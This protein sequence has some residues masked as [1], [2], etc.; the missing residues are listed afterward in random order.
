MSKHFTHNHPG[1]MAPHQPPAAKNPWTNL[2]TH[3]PST[4]PPMTRNPW[5]NLPAP[6]PSPQQ[7]NAWNPWTTHPM[8]P[9]SSRNMSHHYTYQPVRDAA[10][11]P[12]TN[13]PMSPT[14]SRNMSHHYTYQPVRDAAHN[15]WT[16]PRAPNSSASPSSSCSCNNAVHSPSFPVS[17]RIY[18]QPDPRKLRTDADPLRLL[19]DA[20]RPFCFALIII[21]S[22]FVEKANIILIDFTRSNVLPRRLT[23]STHPVSFVTASCRAGELQRLPGSYLTA[24]K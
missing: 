10:H 18:Y 16:C 22:D 1:S 6:T 3:N 4:Q 11:N 23:T 24:G 5:T 8:S 14:S 7:S 15:P 21:G 13:H 12:W 9:T 19:L 2:P 20:L 17:V